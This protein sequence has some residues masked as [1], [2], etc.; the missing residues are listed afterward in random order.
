MI[1]EN[2]MYLMH[3]GYLEIGEEASV[4]EKNNLKTLHRKLILAYQ[5]F[6]LRQNSVIEIQKRTKDTW[7]SFTDRMNEWMANFVNKDGNF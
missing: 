3:N 4:N 6:C 2:R 5:V 7:I 1:L